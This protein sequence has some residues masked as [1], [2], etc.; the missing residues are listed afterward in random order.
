MRALVLG[1]GLQGKA[2]VHDLEK[3][4]VVTEIIAADLDV[5]GAQAYI[6]KKGFEKTRAVGLDAQT[7]HGISMLVK[8]FRPDV[9]I[10]MLPASFD[11]PAARAAVAAGI[12][13]VSTSYPDKTAAVDAAAREKG[14]S[15]LPEMGMDP[16]IDLLMCRKAIGELDEVEGLHSSG[17]GVPEPRLQQ[18][19][20]IGYKITWTFEGVLKAYYRRARYLKDGVEQVIPEDR[21]FREEHIH[22]VEIPGIGSLEGYYN[23]DAVS[24]IDKFGLTGIRDMGRFALRWPGHS[25]FWRAMVELGFL[26]DAPVAMGD[27]A[28][29]PRRFLIQ[30]LT[31]RLQFGPDERDAAIIMV[32]AW[33]KKDGKPKTVTFRLI[34]YRDLET[35][36]FAMN[37][38]VGFTASIA[39][40]MILTGK[41]RSA[42]V[43]NAARDVDP[44]FLLQELGVRGMRVDREIR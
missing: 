19:N 16:G 26:E 7:E 37:R 6:L 18:A 38:T 23:G 29:S 39:A 3:S 28:V 1:M 12:S 8:S 36:L 24:Y 44:D 35:G 15:V 21:I 25:A 31:P 34:D 17:A 2:V 41:I 11:Y 33:G 30:H 13:F 43:L 5:P 14:V 10:C 9:V 4:D 40:Q 22:R 42:G 32:K 27:A 20:P